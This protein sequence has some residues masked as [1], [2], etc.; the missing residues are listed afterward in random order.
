MKT[1]LTAVDAANY[2]QISMSKLYKLT[3]GKLIKHYRRG[4]RLFFL[5]KDL[6]AWLAQNMIA[7]K[8]RDEIQNIAAQ[9]V[10]ELYNEN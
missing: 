3:A 8:S 4:N 6:Q 2:M 1:Y 9:K 5:E 10:E 7:V